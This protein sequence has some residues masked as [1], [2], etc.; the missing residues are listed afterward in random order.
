MLF[1]S[2]MVN[3]EL[4]ELQ[5]HQFV[6]LLVNLA[7]L[8]ENPRFASSKDTSK[9]KEETVPVL[10]CVQNMLNEFL[11]RMSTGNAADFK[12]VSCPPLVRSTWKEQ[13]EGLRLL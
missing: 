5:L 7:F 2:Q 11:P 9:L 8:R 13:R 3:P 4:T 1:Q 6:S 10:Q 12:T